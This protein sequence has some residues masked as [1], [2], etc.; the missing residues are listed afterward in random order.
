MR[1]K[2]S[3][4]FVV[5]AL[6][7]GAGWWMA[8][9]RAG[10]AATR[11]ESGASSPQAAHEPE[12]A[13]TR[14]GLRDAEQARESVPSALVGTNDDDAARSRFE[15]IPVTGSDKR[16][17]AQAE[18]TWIALGP[19]D[20][21]A[22]SPGS[23][24]LRRGELDG[25]LEERGVPIL[26]D[27][28]G[29]LFVPERSEGVC[30]VAQ[31]PGLWGYVELRKSTVFPCLLPLEADWSI[32]ARVV[33]ESGEPVAGARV[34]LRVGVGARVGWEHAQARTDAA[35]LARLHHV[36]AILA[37]AWDHS[38][39]HAI[40]LAEPLVSPVE[41]PL[42][43]ASPPRE[44]LTLVMPP[45]GEVFLQV[46]GATPA[47]FASLTLLPTQAP[48]GECGAGVPT[49][50]RELVDGQVLFPFVGL[51]HD[52]LPHTSMPGMRVHLSARAPGPTR[53]G[54]RVTVRVSSAEDEFLLRGRL[55]HASGKPLEE[56]TLEFWSSASSSGDWSAYYSTRLRTLHDGSFSISLPR[57]GRLP[58]SV[59]LDLNVERSAPATPLKRSFTLA[60]HERE[61]D[62][63]ALEVPADWLDA[64][65]NR[66]FPERAPLILAGH[67]LSVEGK[68]EANAEVHMYRPGA[69]SR[70][71]ATSWEWAGASTADATGRFEFRG[72]ASNAVFARA[73]GSGAGSPFQRFAAGSDAVE[74]VLSSNAKLRG[75][76]LCSAPFLPAF[77]RVTA[78]RRAP[79]EETPFPDELEARIDSD[80]IF[81]LEQLAAGLWDVTVEYGSLEEPLATVEG[82]RIEPGVTNVDPRL[83]P[84]DLAKTGR[85]REVL[86]LD[87]KGLPC[88]QLHVCRPPLVAGGE[89]RA[90]YS[91]TGKLFLN[92]DEGLVWISNQ[93]DRS[94]CIDPAT[95]DD[96]VQLKPVALIVVSAAADVVWPEGCEIRVEL[97]TTP[98]G[99]C[100]FDDPDDEADLIPG[101]TA[102]LECY[103]HARISLRALACG[104][105]EVEFPCTVE[106]LPAMPPDELPAHVTVSWSKADIEAAAKLANP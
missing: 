50:T 80:G 63:G 76:I 57:Q 5:L 106:G 99:E 41:V 24:A 96:T 53:A 52:V 64:L 31:A 56:E 18:L 32:T 66:R 26:P 97:V 21:H 12:S 29:R 25:L 82:V 61:F 54:E 8:Q 23:A 60:P 84:F 28:E 43:L 10:L 1:T 37:R 13:A 34:A 91:R 6:L 70:P 105:E 30:V 3:L 4:A 83:D 35:G 14:E 2:L 73:A 62:L 65:T 15:V 75:R 88:H 17:V 78:R 93:L 40:A 104:A 81:V 94:L 49:G 77:L 42:D 11:I 36:P 9:D 72:V 95:C 45:T 89:A 27:V 51:G 22:E 33:E 92:R 38:Y 44:L 74:L 67:V 69:E 85:W 58:Q 47:S 90:Q 87:S 102:E 39:R 59:H 100:F 86:V 55:V 101:E 68:P 46:E 98:A 103:R 7:L 71:D 16:R 19:V 48:E 79:A 20:K